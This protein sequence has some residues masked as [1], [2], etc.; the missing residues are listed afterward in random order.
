[1]GL[2][3]SKAE[4]MSVALIDINSSSVGGALA[5]IE[6][7]SKPIMYYANRL[8]IEIHGEEDVSTAMIRTL[9]ELTDLLIQKGAPI[10]RQGTKSGHVDHVF[11]SIGAPW[12]ATSVRTERVN[13]AK[14][15]V[16]T[17]AFL[18]EITRKSSAVREGYALSGESVVATILNGYEVQHP[19]GKRVTRAELIILSSLIQKEVANAIEK[20]LRR[21]YHT[22]AL[23]L[24]AFAPVAYTVFRD[25]FPHEKD[26]LILDVSDEATDTAFI[27]RGL[28]VDVA[29]AAHGVNELMR[30]AQS[31]A[32][33]ITSNKAPSPANMDILPNARFSKEVEDSQA[34]WLETLTATLREFSGKNALPRTLFLLAEDTSRDYLKN[35]LDSPKLRSL[36]LTDEPLAIVPVLPSAFSAFI[37]SRAEAGGDIYLALLTLFA[38]KQSGSEA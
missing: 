20:V 8:P 1:M 2:F 31:A 23:T 27:K 12:Q 4:R 10:L 14:P 37:Q 3:S 5:R 21:S 34:A 17:R 30:K 19:F 9:G 11:A 18:N 6:S 38:S 28:L 33:T 15:F 16:F 26:F 36:W 25:I 35:L 24:T 32:R 22:H 29:S 7:G 13:E